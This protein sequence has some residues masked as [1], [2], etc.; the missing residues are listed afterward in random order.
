MALTPSTMAPLGMQ[1]PDF[2][3][4]AIGPVYQ[5]TVLAPSGP[6]TWVAR[7][8][9]PAKGWT[10]F[11]V[12][13]TFPSA[14]PGDPFVFTTEIHVNTN[15][16][17]YAWP[18]P[19]SPES[20]AT[21]ELK[22]GQMTRISYDPKKATFAKCDLCYWREGGAEF[23]NVNIMAVAHGTEKDR[24]LAHKRAIDEHLESVGIAVRYTNVFWGGRSE[25]KPSEISPAAYREW[26]D[27]VGINSDRLRK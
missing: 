27:S 16:P 3:L 10:A 20:T 2:R 6:N 12:E 25:I 7:V 21:N 18:F 11:F 14:I 1:A 19:T 13:L 8:H 5:S 24:V 4:D 26:C 17:L 9:T 15:L 23:R 22:L